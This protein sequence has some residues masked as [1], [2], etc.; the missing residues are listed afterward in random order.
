V[1]PAGRLAVGGSG[2][3]APRRL[4]LDLSWL[5]S[6]IRSGQLD[7]GLHTSAPSL[8]LATLGRCRPLG[9]TDIVLAVATLPLGLADA[10]V[11]PGPWRLGSWLFLV[12]IGAVVTWAT[13]VLAASV[14]L[15]APSVELEVVY[16]GLWQAARYPVGSNGRG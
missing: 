5:P 12:G 11:V 4:A 15:R 8:G 13:R 7:D 6:Q 3:A 16:G 9:L 2:G 1:P 10:G 14:A